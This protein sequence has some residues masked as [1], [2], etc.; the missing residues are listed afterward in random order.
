MMQGSQLRPYFA[1]PYGDMMLA[2]CFGLLTAVAD[3]LPQF[4][5]SIWTSLR[6]GLGKPPWEIVDAG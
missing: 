1:T 4:R 6:D 3:K 2:G 5:Q